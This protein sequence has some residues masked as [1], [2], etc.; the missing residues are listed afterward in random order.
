VQNQLICQLE[1][2]RYLHGT[3]PY[4]YLMIDE[5][6]LIFM[7]TASTIFPDTLD[8]QILWEITASLI[9]GAKYAR[10]Y[11]GFMERTS[12]DVLKGMGIQDVAVA[13]M[14]SS[15]P[16]NGRTMILGSADFSF[17]TMDWLNAWA[18]SIGERVRAGKNVMIFHQFQ[19]EDKYNR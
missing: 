1:S 4:T 15:V 12:M 16:N 14:P 6:Q 3:A 5:S 2:I 10:L 18:A 7:Q 8:V 19:I 9:T 11:D 13:R 17:E